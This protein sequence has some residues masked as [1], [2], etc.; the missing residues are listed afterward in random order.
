MFAQTND[1]GSILRR[2]LW[3]KPCIFMKKPS[4]CWSFAL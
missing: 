4:A 1:K 3:L 2:Q